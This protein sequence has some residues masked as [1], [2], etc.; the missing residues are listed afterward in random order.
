MKKM[1]PLYITFVA[2]ASVS[3]VN[4]SMDNS[5][6]FSMARQQSGSPERS[7]NTPR[8][9]TIA[10]PAKTRNAWKIPAFHLPDLQGKQH[11]LT[12]WKGKVILLNFW[13]SW[14]APCQYEIRDFVKY[15]DKY[16][17]KLQ[18]VSI[19]LDDKKKLANVKRSLEI[20]YPVMFAD[21]EQ[22]STRDLLA[23]WG[24]KDGFI[25]YS[26]II[27]KDGEIH[28]IH[29]GRLDEEAFEDFLLPLIE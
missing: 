22:Q 2:A 5:F 10:L 11:Q 26:I 28:Y 25:P 29:R 4:A 7:M 13:A 27:N 8:T 12:E 6:D 24:N 18:I 21:I 9:A 20:N 3:I 1:M 16:Q 19:G 17:E 15:Q 23:Q 14:C